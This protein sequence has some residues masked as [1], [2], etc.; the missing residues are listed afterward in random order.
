MFSIGY[1]TIALYLTSLTFFF[2]GMF[3]IDHLYLFEIFAAML[4]IVPSVI[5]GVMVKMRINT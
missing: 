2:L 4:F 1:L 3:Y 5:I